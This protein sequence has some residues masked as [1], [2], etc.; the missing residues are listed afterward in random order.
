MFR[1]P[2][3]RAA[4]RL[5]TFE[6]GG[7]RRIGAQVDKEVVD[8]AKSVGVTD[9]RS[10]LNLGSAGLKQAQDAVNSGK[11]RI[12]LKDVTIKAPIDNPEKVICV[13]LNYVDH[14]IESNMAIPTEP[15]LFNKFASS[16][17]G[18]NDVIVKPAT[19]E[20]LDFEAELAIVIG[21][22]GRNISEADALQHV[23]GYTVAHDVSA[24]DWQLKKPGG[25]WLSG[26]TFDT[27]CPLGPA[28]VTEVSNP[29]NLGI[30]CILNGTT[31]Q[32][33]NTNQFIFHPPKLIAYISAIVTLKPGDVILTGTPPGVGFGR[34]PPLYMK[35]GDKV[36]V[37]IDELGSITN[38]IV[39]EVRSSL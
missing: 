26:K 34:N 29:S 1:S 36:T 24:R 33:S 27:F 7:S 12:A 22:G 23:A 17:V 9:M 8:L 6:S 11:N 32:N 5:V 35:A 2:A 31:V 19:T 16:I 14:A 4:L 38:T 18:P 13:G 21:K 39:D 37:E 28:I 25:Q 10:F 20:S 30:R 15:V 3:M